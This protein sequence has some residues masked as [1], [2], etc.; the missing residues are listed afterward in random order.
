[1]TG[2]LAWIVAARAISAEIDAIEGGDLGRQ[3]GR[4]GGLGH[5]RIALN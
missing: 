2:N 5:Q 3:V 4:D 1:M